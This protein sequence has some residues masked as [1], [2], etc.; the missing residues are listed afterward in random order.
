MMLL[1]LADGTSIGLTDHDRTLS[2][3]LGDGTVDYL[4]DTGILPS[5]IAASVGFEADNFEVTGP[6]GEIVTRPAVLGGR[7]DRA[8]VYLFEVNWKSLASGAIRLFAGNISEATVKSGKFVFEVR[9]D[10]DKFNQT[11]GE[12]IT[13]YCSADFCD[14]QC[15]LDLADF[16]TAA[17]VDAVLDA[18]RFSVSYTGTIPDDD[19]N[20]GTILFT[21]GALTGALPIEVQDWAVG[22]D[23]QLFE[24]LPEPPEIGDALDLRFGCLKIRKSD[25]AA[26]RTCMFYENTINMRAYPEV[27]GSDQVLKYANPG[28]GGG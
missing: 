7:F 8:R 12:L 22:G 13:P 28:S 6:I 18:M 3:N 17:T 16:T 23:I 10:A 5:A 26:A 24:P 14:A 19:L 20:K 11:T 25:D 4:P 9:S 1:V 2:F 15:G 27:P 21:S